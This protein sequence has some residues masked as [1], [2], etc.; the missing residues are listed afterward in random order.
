MS[1]RHKK[2]HPEAVSKTHKRSVLVKRLRRSGKLSVGASS[3][4]LSIE[5]LM[6]MNRR[7]A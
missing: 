1:I 6:S 5:Q 7:A 2:R 3:A 4:H